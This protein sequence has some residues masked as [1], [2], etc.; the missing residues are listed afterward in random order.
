MPR[1]LALIVG[2]LALGTLFVPPHEPRADKGD[3]FLDAQTPGVLTIEPGECFT[4]L[5]GGHVRYIP[6]DERGAANQAY[7]FVQVADGPWDRTALAAH[8]WRVCGTG[9]A[10]QWPDGRARGLAYYPVL[11]TAATWAGGDR[12]IMC[13]AYRT[14]GP[15]TGSL[16]P[17]Y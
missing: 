2:V 9:F 14:D 13:A 12:D 4:D 5:T 6:C 11:P 7:G 8:A 1:P 17:R 15:L 16:L 3:A 10:R